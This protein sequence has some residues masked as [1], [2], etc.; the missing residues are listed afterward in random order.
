MEHGF[1]IS[2]KIYMILTVFLGVGAY[3]ASKNPKLK[4]FVK[5]YC[6]EDF[7]DPKEKKSLFWLTIRSK[8]YVINLTTTFNS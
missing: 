5:K 7:K 1:S 3:L 8:P 6:E 2:E 4:E